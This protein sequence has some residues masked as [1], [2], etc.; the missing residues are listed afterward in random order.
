MTPV[1]DRMRRISAD[2]WRLVMITV[3]Y[4]FFYYPTLSGLWPVWLTSGEYSYALAIPFVSGYVIWK[5]KRQ[6][7]A[8][9]VKT[10]WPAA[11]VIAVFW[12]ISLYGILGS[13]PSAVRPAAVLVLLAIVFFC[14][15]R[16][17][18]RLLAF[19]LVFLFFMLPLPTVVDTGI[20]VPLL[21]FSTRLGEL[22]LRVAGVSV[23]VEGNII[24]LGV[25][26][27][28]VV[29]AC[30]GL[31]Y[32]LPLAALGVIYA[33]FR[34]KTRWRQA[35]LVL[36]TVPIA[37]LSNGVR[38][39]VTGYLAQNYG[40]DRAEGFFHGFSGWLIFV[41]AVLLLMLLHAALRRGEAPQLPLKAHD[42]TTQRPNL[43]DVRTF[44]AVSKAAAAV[45]VILL[46]T[47]GVLAVM[48]AKLPPVRL[49]EAVGSFPLALD[50]W[51]GRAETLDSRIVALSGA[52]EAFNA[53]YFSP[54]G[55]IV[56]LYMGYRGSPFTE[57][58]NFFHSPDVCLPSL[59]WKTVES[60]N[61]VIQAVPGFGRL[62]VSKMLIEKTGVRQL[63]YYW[64]QT[65]NRTSSNVHLNRL[66]LSLHAL[67]RDNTYDFFVRPITPLGALEPISSAEERLDGF[68]RSL[69][70]AMGPFLSGGEHSGP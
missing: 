59:G 10:F 69:M 58:E 27:L 46:L 44:P 2:Y 25:T 18:F 35:L 23:Y 67:A 63:V 7:A 11:A 48:V 19:P 51:Q 50:Q 53:A 20:A 64:F 1:A 38:I 3:A 42:L 43:A 17:L 56:S 40:P 30:S 26:Q 33:F 55:E 22:L 9:P 36:A 32:L 66:H 21:F 54:S 31:R 29:D 68:V 41:F 37:V 49:P 28:Q 5:R 16:Y 39:A 4:L 13:S 14:Y 57:S 62:R 12:L 15:G 8:V 65:R 70:A 45:T 60:G 61:H 52:E 47:G 34:E 6:I 24:D